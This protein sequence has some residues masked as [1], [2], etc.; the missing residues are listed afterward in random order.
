MMDG[1]LLLVT[2][3]QGPTLEDIVTRYKSQPTSSVASK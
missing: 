1:K 2:N 3:V